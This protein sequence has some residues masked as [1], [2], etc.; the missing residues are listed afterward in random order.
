MSSLGVVPIDVQLQ[1]SSTKTADA[2]TAETINYNG[3]KGIL[4]IVNCTAAPASPTGGIL[5]VL[6]AK[7]PVTGTWVSISLTT[8]TKVTAAGTKAYYFGSEQMNTNSGGLTG[9]SNTVLPRTWR[10]LLSNSASE[11]FTYSVG[12]TLV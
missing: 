8:L 10:L 7:D 9:A 4:V 6:Q 5:P 3:H 2:Y 11:S 12:A 1:A